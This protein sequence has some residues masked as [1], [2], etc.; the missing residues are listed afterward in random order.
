MQRKKKEFPR[1]G[2]ATRRNSNVTRNV[3]GNTRSVHDLV[4]PANRRLGSLSIVAMTLISSMK[5]LITIGAVGS[6]D[7]VGFSDKS[8]EVRD[9]V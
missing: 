7:S 9:Q 3:W 2:A 8:A 5:S 6:K 1:G 4:S